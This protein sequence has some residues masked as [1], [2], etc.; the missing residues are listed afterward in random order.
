[1]VPPFSKKKKK[2][3][4]DDQVGIILLIIKH[5]FKSDNFKEYFC[6]DELLSS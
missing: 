3:L 1:M 4:E 5:D 6:I 2:I